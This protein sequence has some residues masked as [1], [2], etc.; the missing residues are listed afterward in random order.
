MT[1]GRRM[2]SEAA[3]P[4]DRLCRASLAARPRSGAQPVAVV[5]LLEPDR[6]VRVARRRTAT[7]ARHSHR[8][9]VRPHRR[10]QRDLRGISGGAT[11]ELGTTVQ[12]L[13]AGSRK[14]AKSAKS[15]NA[16][17]RRAAIAAGLALGAEAWMDFEVHAGL[18]YDLATDDD[19]CLMH[20]S[21]R[22]SHGPL[23]SVVQ[24]SPTAA[25][26]RAL[27]RAKSGSMSQP[28]TA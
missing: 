1:R 7:P 6:G 27:R 16:T 11:G 8:A 3:L 10:L 5:G 14:S 20:S 18:R 9:R 23:P 22:S 15:A 28:R 26:T 12:R 2:D 13:Q 25:K 21:V 17:V 4:R 19:L 24:G